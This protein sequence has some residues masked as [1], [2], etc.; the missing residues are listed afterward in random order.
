MRC[1]HP[2]AQLDLLNVEGP[3]PLRL[4]SGD[5]VQLTLTYR[6]T[7]CAAAPGGAWPVTAQVERPWGRMAVNVTPELDFDTWLADVVDAYCRR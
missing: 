4:A 2:R 7:D 5:V 3:F 1:L 6:I